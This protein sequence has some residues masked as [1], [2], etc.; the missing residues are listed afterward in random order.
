MPIRV[1]SEEI[2][3]RIAA[4]E[5]IERPASV[6][7]EL[8]ENALDAGATRIEV[9]VVAGGTRLVA[10]TDNGHGIEPGE[11]AVAFQ[12]F[13]TSKIDDTSDLSGI[14]TLGFRGEAL[15]SI[16]SVSRVEAVSCP[17]GQVSGERL[18]IEFGRVIS[19]GPAAAAPGTS[20]RV[21]ELFRNVPARLKFLGSPGGELAKVQQLVASFAL[22][23]PA[24]AFRLVSDSETRLSSAGDGNRVAAVAAVYGARVA[25][26]MLPVV[27]DPAAAFAVEGL[28]SAPELS[29]GNR[30][31]ITL[32]VNGR[33]V[34]SRRLVFAVEQA[35]HGFLPERRFPVAVLDLRVPYDDVDV[36]VHPAKAE[37][38]LL[39]E[40]LVFSEVQR[41]VRGTL[42]ATSPVRDVRLPW[43][44]RSTGA[45]SS[46]AGSPVAGANKTS[47]DSQAQR[48]F[49]VA[50]TW[51]GTD[52]ASA[53]QAVQSWAGAG[54]PG[55][56]PSLE[57]PVAG[58]GSAVESAT[59]AHPGDRTV[60]KAL[61][62]LRVIGQAHETYIL[63]E[64]PDGVY[65]VDQH[66]A[67][68]RVL[69]EGLRAR[70]H[71]R[72]AESQALVEAETV[73]LSP[74]QA[75]L[76]E[77]QADALARAGFVIAPFGPKTVLVRAVPRLL[78][79]RGQGSVG[80]ILVRLLDEGTDRGRGES[81][82]DRLLYTMACHAAVRAGRK[83]TPDECRE[84]LRQLEAAEQPHTCPHGRP[85]MVHL[86]SGHL[87]RE[88]GRR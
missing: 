65:L 31:Y 59:P 34:H 85:T 54:S 23:R 50:A 42:S 55:G 21:T 83:M 19:T 3:S 29:R 1:L 25:Q 69:Y 36:N 84:L 64:G 66:A 77:A 20:V 61:P 86:A 78:A 48:A 17:A 75:A 6:V 37:V 53:R 41:A 28:T 46:P 57:R 73:E 38:R 4:G 80:D 63:A 13:A 33:W 56:I 45:G 30:T 9:E 52:E 24:V 60:H 67:H 12:R 10:V 88:F 16:A 35:Y 22:I 15:P 49:A 70:L 5:V 43:L 11:A 32:A 40:D 44:P 76:V 2:S 87:E 62:V 82:E 74:D 47:P 79:D 26:A 27:S 8:V 81:W 18:V 7:K 14:R 71:S 58:P 68:E 72:G 39:R 51:P